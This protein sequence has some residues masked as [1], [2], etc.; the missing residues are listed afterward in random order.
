MRRRRLRARVRHRAQA[1]ADC[2]PVEEPEDAVRGE[3]VRYD[4]GLPLPLDG[5]FQEFQCHSRRVTSM[6]IS[7]DDS[8]LFCVSDDGC[9]SVFDIR[10][11]DGQ[12]L[13]KSSKEPTMPFAEEV[14]VTK[15]DMEEKRGRMQELEMQVAELTLQSEYQ[16]RLKDLNMNEKIKDL[17]EKFQ[18]E[19]DEDKS[20]FEMLLQEKNEQE[21]EYEEKIKQMEENHASQTSTTE[22]RYQQKIITEVERYQQLLREKE[23]LNEVGRAELPAGDAPHERVVEE[24]PPPHGSSPISCSKR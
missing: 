10:D 23:V 13:K 8:M 18:A 11:K 6:R 24:P 16:L 19:L 7:H 3:R 9:M 2:A 5:E 22:D 15:A 4:S 21:M 20:K 14:L 12:V 17:T 1:H